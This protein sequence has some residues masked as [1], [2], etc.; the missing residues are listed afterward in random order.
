[1]TVIDWFDLMV[2]R[3]NG[4]IED[5]AD[6][7]PNVTYV[8]FQGIYDGHEACSPKKLTGGQ[9]INAVTYQSCESCKAPASAASFHPNDIGHGAAWPEVFRALEYG[10]NATPVNVGGSGFR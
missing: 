10:V 8:D 4:V 5:V 1:M 3:M 2:G 6:Q 7:Y 9:W